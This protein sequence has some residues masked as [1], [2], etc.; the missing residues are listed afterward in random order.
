MK[1]LTTHVLDTL[2]GRPA[3]G[4]RVELWQVERDGTPINKIIESVTQEEGRCSLADELPVAWYEL[5]FHIGDY[6]FSHGRVNPEFLGI[7]PIRFFLADS[8]RH[9]HIPLVASPWS[10]ASYKG[11]MTPTA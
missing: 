7:V 9:Y 8:L 5:R 1:G 2:N 4:V 10:L 3:A 6:F 11:G